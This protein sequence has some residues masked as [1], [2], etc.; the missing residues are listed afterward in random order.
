MFLKQYAEKAIAEAAGDM[1]VIAIPQTVKPTTKKQGDAA[2]DSPIDWALRSLDEKLD[3]VEA[4]PNPVH[5]AFYSLSRGPVGEATNQG[6]QMAGRMAVNATVEGL[7]LAAPVGKWAV[8]QGFK[9]AVNLMS[10]AMEFQE[11]AKRRKN[12]ASGTTLMKKKPP[13]KPVSNA[14]D[15]QRTGGAKSRSKRPF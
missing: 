6:V 5:R 2:N 1:P 15:V 14:K 7:K 10:A 4:N 11:E 12:E 9:A 8:Q 3:E 13:P